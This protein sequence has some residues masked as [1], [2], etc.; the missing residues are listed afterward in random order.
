MWVIR[1]QKSLQ[2]YIVMKNEGFNQQPLGVKC[3]PSKS[4]EI[5]VKN[6]FG[7][8]HVCVFFADIR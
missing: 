6:K 4:N 1:S 8:L 7:I 5:G 2:E 3:K